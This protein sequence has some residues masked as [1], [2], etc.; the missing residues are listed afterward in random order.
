MALKWP[1]RKLPQK[2]HLDKR[3]PQI[4]KSLEGRADDELLST[5]EV[6]A[7]LGVS[8]QWLEVGRSLGLGL[9]YEVLGPRC[10]KYKI[11][12]IRK[13]LRWRMREHMKNERRKHDD[14]VLGSRAERRSRGLRHGDAAGSAHSAEGSSTARAGSGTRKPRK[15]HAA[16]SQQRGVPAPASD[17]GTA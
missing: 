10:I 7:L 16:R 5:P 13:F 15:N 12:K 17:T 6:A 1:K 2:F 4:L 11:G 14:E 8:K 3:A 9:E